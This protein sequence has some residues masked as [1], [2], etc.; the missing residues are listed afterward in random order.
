[1]PY[2]LQ[3]T[4]ITSDPKTFIDNIFSTLISNEVISGYIIATISD[5]LL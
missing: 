5:H 2:I 4:R 3:P 1:M